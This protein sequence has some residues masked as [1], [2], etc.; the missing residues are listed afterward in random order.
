MKDLSKVIYPELSYKILG[1]LFEVFNILGPDHRESVY[2]KALEKEFASRKIDFTSQFKADLVYKDKVI[3]VQFLDFLV[4][5]KIVV[6]LK[7]GVY[8]RKKSFDQ[9][10][11]YLKSNNMRLGILALFSPTGLKYYRI[12]NDV[13]LPKTR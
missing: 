9:I 4:E 2:Q 8:Y 5:G 13:G 3:G 1:C 7:V 10:L 11:D 12:L 6:E